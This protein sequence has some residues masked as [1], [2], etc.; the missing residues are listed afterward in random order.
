MHFSV[1]YE[2]DFDRRVWKMQFE[3][4]GKEFFLDE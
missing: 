1:E 4:M 3:E 2:E